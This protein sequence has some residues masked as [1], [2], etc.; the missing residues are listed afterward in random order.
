MINEF[1]PISISGSME[2]RGITTYFYSPSDQL[3]IK[4]RAL[5]LVCPG[6]GYSHLSD[7]EGEPVALQF[8]SM[9]YHSAV[10]KYSLS[11][12]EYPSELLEI[13]TAIKFFKDNADKYGIDPDNIY[14]YGASAGSHL[15]ALFGTGYFRPEVTDYLKVSSDYLKPAGLILSYPVITEGEFAHK[16]SF[17][18]LLGSRSEDEQLRK[19]VSIENRVDEHAPEAFIWHTFAD[20]AV[21]VENSLLL[22][23]AYR[24]AGIPFELHIFPMGGHGLALANELTYS[25]A[26][27]EEEAAAAQWITL[28]KTWLNKH[29]GS[30]LE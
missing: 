14:I 26:R 17:T 4:K 3:A 6:G 5:I 1:I 24:K 9:G 21:P 28:V 29:I 15:A 22:A 2:G 11:P 7:R 25:N 16:G 12:S 23:N 10:L 18:M 27:S 8:M 30:M 20:G 19:Y 13:A